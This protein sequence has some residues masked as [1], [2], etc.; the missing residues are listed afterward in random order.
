MCQ[1]HQLS[2]CSLRIH[3]TQEGHVTAKES[4]VRPFIFI[5]SQ[6]KLNDII[7][8]HLSG[9]NDAAMLTVASRCLYLLVKG[10]IDSVFTSV[11]PCLPVLGMGN[12]LC[13]CF[14]QPSQMAA[15]SSSPSSMFTQTR[16]NASRRFQTISLGAPLYKHLS[17]SDLLLRLFLSC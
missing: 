6:N 11:C 17:R 9:R 5:I 8:C 3:F 14:W 16:A 1:C 15:R 13:V 10:G 4:Q 7:C 12:V 2:V